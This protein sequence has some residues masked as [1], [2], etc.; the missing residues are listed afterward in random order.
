MVAQLMNGIELSSSSEWEGVF[1]KGRSDNVLSAISKQ[2]LPNR[3]INSCHDLVSYIG[4]ILHI[5]IIDI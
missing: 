1:I 3:S 4:N 5:F 2:S